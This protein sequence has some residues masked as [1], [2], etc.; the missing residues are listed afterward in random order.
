IKSAIMNNVDLKS[1]LSGRCVT[2]GRIN[3]FASL[4]SSLPLKAKFYGVPDTTIKPLRI[5]FYDVSE[6]IISSRLWNFGDGNTTGEVNPSHTYYNPGIYTVTLQVNDGV[7]TH[8]SVL[9][10]QGG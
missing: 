4:A 1:G 10:I 8:A 2:G 7:G 5:R 6:G 9:E 3:A